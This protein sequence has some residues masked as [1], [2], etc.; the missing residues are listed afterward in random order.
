[1]YE[2]SISVIIPMHNS[3][4]YIEDCIKSILGQ[5]VEKEI[6]LVDDGSTDRT[7]EIC[8][9]L[10]IKHPCIHY[11]YKDNSGVSDARNMGL[12]RANG[13]YVTFVDSDD[14]LPPRALK[15]LLSGLKK[16]NV[17]AVF[18]NHAYYYENGKVIMRN[19]RIKYGIYSFE[20]VKNRIIDDGTLTGIL[21][22]SVCGGGIEDL[23]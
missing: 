20:D 1:M 11:Y 16:Y 8:R 10:E 5:N 7:G 9:E 3:A 14:L 2:E 15:C 12:N 19:L 23:L 13:K 6:I 17:D 21:F 18:G 4:D 22:G